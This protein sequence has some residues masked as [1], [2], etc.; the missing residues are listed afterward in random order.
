M[1][2]PAVERFRKVCFVGTGCPG[3]AVAFERNLR[4]CERTGTDLSIFGAVEVPPAAMLRLMESLGFSFDVS[5]DELAPLD[6]LVDMARQRN[7]RVTAEL[8][9]A[10][11]AN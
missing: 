8:L 4:L 6:Q 7:I 11:Q 5:R 10:C 9:R 3:D 1:N 2:K